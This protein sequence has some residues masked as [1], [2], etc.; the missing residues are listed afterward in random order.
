[1]PSE[2][3]SRQESGYILLGSWYFLHCLNPGLQ[4][5]RKELQSIGFG[6]SGLGDGQAV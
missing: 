2:G 1:M 6:L 5:D 4:L 3:L